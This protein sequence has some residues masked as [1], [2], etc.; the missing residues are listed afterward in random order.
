[1]AV[2]QFD[3]RSIEWL[4]HTKLIYN[5]GIQHLLIDNICRHHRQAIMLKGNG[6]SQHIVCDLHRWT[7]NAQ[8]TLIEHRFFQNYH[9]VKPYC[10]TNLLTGMGY[11]LKTTAMS[12]TI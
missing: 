1:M 9:N 2:N 7:Y 10:C 6:N 12:T 8:G 5:D 4:D 3:Y 11:C